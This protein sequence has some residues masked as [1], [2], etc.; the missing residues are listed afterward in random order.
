MKSF[1]LLS[2]LFVTFAGF[3][4][5]VVNHEVDPK[6]AYKEID[7]KNGNVVKNSW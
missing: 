3:S 2:L 5:N 1:L 4:Q 7:V 6:G